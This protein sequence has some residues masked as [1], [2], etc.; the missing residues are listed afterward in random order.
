MKFMQAF[1]YEIH[2]IPTANGG[3]IVQIGCAQLAYSSLNK[4]LTDLR[5]MFK[6]PEAAEKAYNERP[7]RSTTPPEAPMREPDRGQVVESVGPTTGAG[8]LTRPP[9]SESSP[10]GNVPLSE[11]TGQDELP[12]QSS[13]T[14]DDGQDQGDSGGG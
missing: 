5:W 12:G 10:A 7:G 14:Q 9:D 11:A 4:M 8:G 6:D 2:I 1:P 3:A 13:K